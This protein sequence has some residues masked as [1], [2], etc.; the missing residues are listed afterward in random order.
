MLKMVSQFIDYR[1]PAEE[2]KSGWLTL[3]TSPHF[4][5]ENLYLKLT[6]KINWPTGKPDNQ[7]TK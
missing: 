3:S 6:N 2:L 4:A 5:T 7:T 1:Y